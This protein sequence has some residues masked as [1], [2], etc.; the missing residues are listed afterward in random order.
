MDT[1]EKDIMNKL[2]DINL[3]EPIKKIEVHAFSF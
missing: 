1:V 3:N 2:G